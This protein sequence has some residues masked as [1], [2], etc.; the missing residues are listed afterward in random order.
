MQIADRVRSERSGETGEQ[1]SLF[2]PD[3][4]LE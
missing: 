2:A 3:V 1:L 4:E